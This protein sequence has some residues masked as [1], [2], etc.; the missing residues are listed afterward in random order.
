MNHQQRRWIPGRLL[1]AVLLAAA[2]CLPAVGCGAMANSMRI[3][4]MLGGAD[5]DYRTLRKAVEADSFPTPAEA[6]I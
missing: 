4:P 5:S 6:G 1:R 2:V 3:L